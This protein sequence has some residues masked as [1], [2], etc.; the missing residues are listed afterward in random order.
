MK[1]LLTT[2]LVVGALAG[3]VFAQGTVSLGLQ[4]VHLAQYTTD[5]TTIIP[6]PVGNPA[7]VGSYGNLNIQVY[8]APAGTPAPFTAG[9]DSLIPAPWTA[10][11]TASGTLQQITTIAGWTPATTFTLPGATAGA[12][13]ELM[14]VGWTGN[15]ADWNS[16]FAA[17][18]SL[19]G[20]TGSALSGGALAWSNPTGGAGSPPG[21]PAAITIGAAGYNG[22]VLT[23][24]PE[25][26]TFALAGL[27][28][29]ALMIFRRR[30]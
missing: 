5:G 17:G 12:N 27:G 18:T 21:L 6:I 25:P 24:V 9:G 28:A 10:A 1:K 3:S 13:A 23:G 30:K 11:T 2:A 22:L 15:F 29:A 26:S 7:Q 16:A 19:M 8:W 4:N 20:W 14:V